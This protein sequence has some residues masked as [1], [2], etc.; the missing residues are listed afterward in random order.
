MKETLTDT[1]STLIARITD[2]EALATL[3]D[4]GRR[5]TSVLHLGELL[6][7][8]PDLIGRL[9]AFDAFAIY[10]LDE[11]R[12]ELTIGYQVGYPEGLAEQVRL[13]VGEGVV[14]A[15]VAEQRAWLV[16]DLSTEPRHLGFVPGVQSSLVV[17]LVYRKRVIGALNILSREL[18][19]FTSSHLALVRQ[20]GT[21]VAVALVNARLFE[22][23]RRDAETFELLA[24]IGR[25][26]TS[27]LDLDELLARIAQLTRRIIDYRSFCIALLNEA[28]NLLEVRSAV[29]YGDINT[30]RPMQL[31]EGLVGY[32]AEHRQSVLVGD[33]TRDPR[34]IKVM[35]DV[36]SEVAIPMIYKD[37]C[38]GVLDIASPE[39]DAFEKRDLHVLEVLASQAAVAVENARLYEAVAANEERLEREVRFAQRVQAALL[40]L[41]LPKRLRN[42]DVGVRFASAR[43]LGGD[44]HELLTAEA[45]SLVV[46]VGDVSGKGVPAALYGVFAAELVR[47]RTFRKPYL[48]ERSTPAGVLAS[49][50]TILHQRQLEEYYCTLCYAWFDLKRR[51]LTLANSGLPYPVHCNEERAVQIEQA[52]VPL[53]A[54][55]ESQYDE[56]TMPLNAGDLFIFCSDGIFEAMNERGEEF[57]AARLLDVARQARELPAQHIVDAVFGAVVAF[58]GNAGQNDDM[59]AVA[60]KILA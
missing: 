41:G 60:V 35:E 39:V 21:H 56:I 26:V 49:I 18:G 19:A 29:Q 2:R 17:P 48:P 3:F 55:A 40:P 20:F 38:I 37:R 54:F 10:L 34:Y 25:D 46:A 4:L 28:T 30:V 51:I 58:R 43:E 12:S 31:G 1:S 47:S 9:I 5:V 36:R 11:K 14:G 16:N 22:Q 57:G 8:I 23:Q 27:I 50:N 24:E 32:A 44:F 42:V 52:G 7:T 6:H 33:V 15:A 45:G 13:R 53:G 59:T